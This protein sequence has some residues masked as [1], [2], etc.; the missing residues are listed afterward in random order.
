[1]RTACSKVGMSGGLGDTHDS[2]PMPQ[3]GTAANQLSDLD[4]KLAHAK[5]CL[6][7]TL[8]A[9]TLRLPHLCDAHGRRLQLKSQY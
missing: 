6:L 4:D 3:P 1:M 2:H 9:F 5:R 8:A 7:R